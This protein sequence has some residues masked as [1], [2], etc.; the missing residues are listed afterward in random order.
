MYFFFFSSRRRHTRCAL[1]TG[2]Q[3]C[4]LPICP[5]RSKSSPPSPSPLRTTHERQNLRTP[6]PALDFRRGAE[7]ALAGEKRDAAQGDRQSAHAS[8]GI[9]QGSRQA[10]WPE[11]RQTALASPAVSPPWARRSARER[12]GR[13]EEG[14]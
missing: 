12:A 14:A 2:V 5:R 6:P 11:E 4:A 1:V 7:A 8:R 13:G 9:G 3:T 10:G